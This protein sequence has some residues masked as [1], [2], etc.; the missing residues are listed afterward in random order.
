MSRNKK[1]FEKNIKKQRKISK[2]NKKDTKKVLKTVSKTDKLAKKRGR[3]RKNKEDKF[4]K[5]ATDYS[6][7]TTFK[8][9]VK[10]EMLPFLSDEE[11]KEIFKTNETALQYVRENPD[12]EAW[13]LDAIYSELIRA[14]H[15]LVVNIAN[16]LYERFKFLISKEDIDNACE[17]GL[18]KAL[19]AYDPSKSTAKF[20]SFATSC[21][22]NEGR[23][24]CRTADRYYNNEAS[25][26]APIG[27]D[28]Q[29][30]IK[31]I[32]DVQEAPQP[33]NENDFNSKP[34]FKFLN[35]RLG[36]CEK[37][38]LFNYNELNQNTYLSQKQ[39]ALLL[40]YP[41]MYLT[42]KHT[43]A[44]QKIK[45]DYVGPVNRVQSDE[46]IEEKES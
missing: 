10:R 34:F 13:K 41:K 43:Q 3:P 26:D 29:G 17:F 27:W 31:T 9:K 28:N 37:Y 4:I 38:V 32:A 22:L 11:F 6:S 20:S 45:E 14:N 23:Y 35:S 19:K 16:N 36:F 33:K 15:F 42:S 21:V 39:M 46:Y 8:L 12:M 7:K 44:K 5:K 24:A 1:E 18:G 2:T 30:N 40:E 25:I